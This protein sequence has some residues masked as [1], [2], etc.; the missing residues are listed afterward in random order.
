MS[1]FNSN[2]PFYDL[3]KFVLFGY[4]LLATLISQIVMMNTLI[5]ILSNSFDRVMERKTHSHHTIK[6][7]TEMYA[8]FMYQIKL[9]GDFFNKFMSAP[10]V[11]VIRP[12]VEDDDEEWEGAVSLILNAN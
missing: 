5:A 11:Y 10:Y 6:A 3:V 7:R 2:E 12:A 4:F 1:D 9:Q 8:E